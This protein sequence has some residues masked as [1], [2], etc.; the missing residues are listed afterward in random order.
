MKTV[1]S[2]SRTRTPRIGD[3]RNF[4][5]GYPIPK[6]GYCDQPYVV[7]TGAGRWV[8][9]MTTGK[10]GEGDEGQHIV[11]A[12]STDSGR[13]WSNP[14]AIEP[15]DGPEA[16]WVMPFIVPESG[17]VYAFY[18][19]NKNDL[20]E[21]LSDDGSI[22]R[23]DLLGGYFFRFSDD[24]GR[25]WSG[26]RY[27]IPV[28]LFTGDRE[29]PYGG[30]VRFFWGVGKPILHDGAMYLGFAKIGRFGEGVM[31][32]SEGAFLKSTNILTESD[33]EKII[34][35]TLPDGE[36]GL[37]APRDRVADEHNPIGLSNGGLYCTYRTIEGYSAHAYSRDGGHTWTSPEYACY[38]RGG[39]RIKHP[40]AANFVKRLGPNRYLLWFHN[41]GTKWYNSREPPG[42]RNVAWITAGREVD[43]F[44][45]WSE[46]EIILFTDDRH[47]GPSYP[48]FVQDGGRVY[49]LATQK[50]EARVNEVDQCLLADLWHQHER[51]ELSREGLLLDLSEQEI[52]AGMLV[53]APRLT[54]LRGPYDRAVGM[55]L[56]IW[57][58]FDDPRSGQE[59]VSNRDESGKGFALV[60]SGNGSVRIELCDGWRGAYWDSDPGI[61]G[62][63]RTHHVV[64]ILDASARVISFVIDGRLNDGGSSRP[65]G[66]GR[67][68]PYLRDL[69]GSDRVRI[70]A[71]L[72]GNLK[73]L[74]LY[75]RHLRTTEAVGN[76]RAGP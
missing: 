62:V 21:V 73:S 10:G 70:A 63:N 40:R 49:V 6:E 65:F 56:D 52:D 16:S 53:T 71:D 47:K 60:T 48:D 44:M 51:C 74:R 28:R 27:E 39:R 29:N 3:P 9:V 13:S 50:T 20:R 36:V 25:S 12:T 1:H 45:R 7:V 30:T 31:Y 69:N 18:T 33:P 55:S 37:R 76:F 43:G 15:A 35:E 14:V 72:K 54:L 46:P 59:I 38:R 8:C 32:K 34:F 22:K 23:V 26:R 58:R 24:E 41:N 66:W 67:L 68:S 2:G 4:A 5:T 42:N 19:Y 61:L 75:D 11:S 17:R 64:M 57:I